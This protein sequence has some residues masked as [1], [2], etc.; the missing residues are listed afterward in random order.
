MRGGFSW[1]GG[2]GGVS[3]VLLELRKEFV[4][5]GENG[6]V[7]AQQCL[8]FSAHIKEGDK[9]GSQW[10]APLLLGG[11]HGIMLQGIKATRIG[12]KLFDA[13]LDVGW[14]FADNFADECFTRC[15]VRHFL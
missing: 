1:M 12:T 7:L 6:R 11:Y 3:L 4:E 2:G 13:G 10:V 15:N 5:V 8:K 9:F 14:G